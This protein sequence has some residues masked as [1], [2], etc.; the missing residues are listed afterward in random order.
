MS[1]R[2][3]GLPMQGGDPTATTTTTPDGW[4]T[5]LAKL[6]PAESLGLYGATAGL[7]PAMEDKQTIRLVCL[8]VIAVICLVFSIVIR[9]KS[10]AAATGSPQV[11]AI[12][13]SAVSFLIWLATLGAPNSPFPIPSDF[14]FIPS[15]IALLWT[16]I[17][18]FFYRGD[19]GEA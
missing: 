10:T 6:I 7:L 8:I 5:R 9:W 13:I 11:L 3:H 17:V 12:I 2:I 19:T 4:A 18:A 16:T 1:L 14:T 15:V